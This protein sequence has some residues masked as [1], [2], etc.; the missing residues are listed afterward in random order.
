MGGVD[1]FQTDLT[2]TDAMNFVTFNQDYSHLAV[3]TSR[4]F[5]IFTTDPF[6]KVYEARDAGNVALLEMLFSTSLVALVLSPRRLQIKNT[7]RGSVICEL[8]FPASILAVRLN[9]KRLV[10]VLED[11]I[12]LYDIQTMKLLYTIET[13]PNPVPI[14]ALSPSSD[15]CYLAYPLPQ[16]SAAAAFAV[17]AHAP[18]NSTHIAPTTGELLIFDAI[19][20]EAIN[21]VEAHRSPLSCVTFNNE[22]TIMATAS[23]K[24]TIIRVFSVPD[25]HKLY[26]FRRGS[27]PSRIFS[28]AF[29]I[30]SSLLC[31]S[32]ATETIHIFK[33][34]A[35]QSAASSSVLPPIAPESKS[36]PP[37]LLSYAF[38]RRV[39]QGSDTGAS[40][41]SPRDSAAASETA[42]GDEDEDEDSDQ[43]P[44][45][46]TNRKPNGTFMGL[47][48]RTSQN[49]SSSFATTVGGYLP[50]GLKSVVAMSPHSPQVMVVTNEGN[51]Y[52]FAVDLAK[53][54][55]ASLIK[56]YSYVE[57][58][59]LSNAL[60]PE[61]LIIDGQHN[62][63][64]NL[65]LPL[66]LNDP[67]VQ[68]AV[69]SVAGLHMWRN[70]PDV[71]YQADASRT[72][73]IQKLK[74][75]SMVPQANK[76]FTLSTWMTL[77][78]LLL[79]EL[80]LG[81]DH[82]MYLLRMMRSLRAHGIHDASP[83]IIRFLHKQ[84]DMLSLLAQP[85]LEDPDTA[86]LSSNGGSL[87]NLL[88]ESLENASSGSDQCT[89]NTVIDAARCCLEMFR[90]RVLCGQD[91]N[92]ARLEHVKRLVS[93]IHP[94]VAGGTSLVWIYF[95]AAA[96][97][98]ATE[99]RVFFTSRLMDI[100]KV[101]GFANI[102]AGLSMLDNL[103][104]RV[105]QP[106]VRV[107]NPS[108]VFDVLIVGAGYSGLTAARDTTTTGLRT[109]ILEGRDRIGGRTW[110]S[111]IDGYQYEMGGTWVHWFQPHVYRE[112]SRYGM[113]DEL[114]H[115]TDYTKKKS[116]FTFVTEHGRRNMSHEEEHELFARAIAKFVNIDGNRGKT[117]MPLP[118]KGQ[119][120][121]EVLEYANMSV[122]DRIEQIRHNLSEDERHAI[123][124]I[125]LVCSGG[126]RDNSSFLDFLRWWAAAGFNYEIFM[127]TV[128]VFKLKC[129]QSGFATKF[130]HEALATGRL[131]YSFN[132][133]VSEIE[134]K[135]DNLVQ[136]KTSD[137]RQFSARRVISTVPLNVLTKV[138]FT[139]PLDPAKTE[140][141]TLKHV[142]QCVKLHAEIKDFE[143]R[144][145]GGITYPNNKLLQGTADGTTPAGNTHCVFFGY[146][147]NPLHPDENIDEAIKAVQAFEPM[148]VERLVFHNWVKD[149]FAEGTWVWYRPGMEVKYLE[150]LRKRQGPVLFANSDWA[151]G[152]WR[153]FIDGAIQ[154][155][156]GAAL[157][158]KSELLQQQA[159]QRP[160]KL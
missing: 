77:L 66:A 124:A 45:S 4:G 105:I 55:E 18:P 112:L 80:A 10:V 106:Q 127:E 62:G 160:N 44:T 86:R 137:G 159:S 40:S 17:P 56:Q 2:L 88:Y 83:E 101:T 13:S 115:S 81:G 123:E 114:V 150:A 3:G 97:S 37:S 93:D 36:N 103:W 52:V 91:R 149:E 129:G 19:K 71:C 141:A 128:I 35:P 73:V 7:K 21:V 51:F 121:K 32:S 145:W 1:L 146:S 133:V 70:R 110:T 130:F 57:T 148:P 107:D 154:E 46:M 26:Q 67:L 68:Q 156:T 63:Y 25:A 5:R 33:L 41:P 64:R 16:K 27:M 34:A 23:D 61:M 118:Y 142:N 135:N 152:G 87:E 15:N 102:P 54:G 65:I 151:Q 8:T 92:T 72:Q 43:S 53:G 29:N 6:A 11:Q 90:D 94:S 125:V 78:V 58:E 157:V 50:K 158:V 59:G 96:A 69:S 20:L 9:R 155:G 144:S 60:A 136:V 139:P 79:G 95:I 48:R 74:E 104:K 12:Y 76:V 138:R 143:R 153:S 117:V 89:V 85:F 30:T 122:A 111:N 134:S 100:Y 47:I 120:S 108:E 126:T 98:T 39:S 140:A 113:K 119:W 116:Y 14:C 131:S 24:G 75:A 42:A 49:V 132:T 109:L 84:T 82:Y 28:L 38:S 99:D 31:V 22:G 147:Q